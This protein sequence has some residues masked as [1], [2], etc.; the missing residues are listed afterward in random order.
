MINNE[1]RKAPATK[2]GY[3]REDKKKPGHKA[4][5]R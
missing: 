3:R 1:R 4:G 5:L 2:R